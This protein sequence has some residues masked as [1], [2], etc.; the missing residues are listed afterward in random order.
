MKIPEPLRLK[1]PAPDL[2]GEIAALP[3]GSGVY[4]LT[5]EDRA[6][7]LSWSANLRRRLLRLLASA[8][9]GQAL[10]DRAASI[11]CWATGSKLETSLLMYQLAKR[12][13]PADYLAR[14][15]LRMP[16]FVRLKDDPFPRLVVVNQITRKGD[17][18]YGP[19]PS[20]DAAQRYE[21][22]LLGLFQI[23]RCTETLAP[24]PGHP[25]CIYGEIGQCSR[26]CQEA[27][28][29]VE[30]AGEVQRVAEFLSTNG[31]S[32]VAAL[33][34]A[35]EAACERTEFEQAADIHKKI[36]RVK[37]AASLRDDAITEIHNFHGVA[38]TR[39][40]QPFE[41]RLWPMLAGLWQEPLLL[42]VAP[43]QAR[44]KSL[45]HEVR[46]RLSESIANPRRDGRPGE[47]LALFRRWYFSSW[48]DGQW[49]PF[50]SLEDL[51]YRRLVREISKM[52]QA[53]P[54]NAQ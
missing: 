4:A 45:D 22:E 29:P 3:A 10:R 24:H 42:N 13:F 52:A 14:L 18:V 33:S 37:A 47:E 6:P 20:R 5:L 11:D 49:F 31:K 12:H 27:V 34:Q 43:D 7:H 54:A 44:G 36:E 19:F 53:A 50:R 46:E 16:W 2:T 23:R 35:R 39:G 40:V 30:Y 48:R 17:P 9:V 32:T 41:F 38:L 51:N 15:R 25:G 8:G 26:P 21:Q 1:L 28:T